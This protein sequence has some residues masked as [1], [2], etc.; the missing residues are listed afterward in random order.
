MSSTINASAFGRIVVTFGFSEW[1]NSDTRRI[2]FL[3]QCIARHFS[4]DW[5]DLDDH[6]R[7]MNDEAFKNKDG[8]RLL[9]SYALPAELIGDAPDDKLWIITDGFGNDPSDSD[10]CHTTILF[11]SEY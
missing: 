10:Q 3:T 2:G 5:G 9:S 6:D 7:S 1:S 11:P 8:S 4:G